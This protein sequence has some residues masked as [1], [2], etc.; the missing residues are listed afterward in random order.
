MEDPKATNYGY[1]AGPNSAMRAEI[2]QIV[3]NHSL[4]DEPLMRIFGFLSGLRADTQSIVVESLRLRSASL[5]ATI[6]TLLESASLPINISE[7]LNAALVTFKMMTQQ[8]NKIVHWAWGLSPDGKDEAPISHPTKR[9]SDGTP[10]SETM[11]LLGLRK[12]GLELIQVYS[13]LSMAAGLLECEVP[14][15][16]GS[17]SLSQ[18]DNLIEKVRLAILEYPEVE[19]EELPLS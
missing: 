1:K 6:T 4:C 14:D 15:E 16:L 10:R 13:L 18:F 12:I 5:A 8:R 7:R 2:G 11:T 19:A 3:V 9:N 17:A